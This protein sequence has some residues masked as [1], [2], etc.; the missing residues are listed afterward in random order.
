MSATS[1]ALLNQDILAE[2]ESASMQPADKSSKA[3]PS[4]WKRLLDTDVFQVGGPTLKDILYEVNRLLFTAE[5]IFSL[6]RFKA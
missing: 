6:S 5:I 2:M 4:S 3:D 1:V